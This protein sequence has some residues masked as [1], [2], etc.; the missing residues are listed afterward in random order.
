LASQPA[1]GPRQRG[2][3]AF[4]PRPLALCVE[5]DPTLSLCTRHPTLRVPPNATG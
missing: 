1:E 2:Q 5:A 3:V 4:L